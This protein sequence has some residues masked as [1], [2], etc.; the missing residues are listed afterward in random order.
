MSK[1]LYVFDL[2]NTLSNGTK[3]AKLAGAEPNRKTEREAYDVWL[4]KVMTDF[5]QDPHIPELMLLVHRLY[6]DAYTPAVIL[7]ARNEEHRE[8]T[9][10][11]LNRFFKVPPMLLMRPRHNVQP[12]GLLKEGIIKDLKA[13]HDASHVT[14][15]DDDERGDLQEVCKKNGWL[16]LKVCL[17]E[18]P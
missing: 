9:Q 11:W 5:H 17:P 6:T 13:R 12:S 16:F 3:R 4:S 10:E 1:L 15:I 7:T 8:E 18:A 2:D 14:V